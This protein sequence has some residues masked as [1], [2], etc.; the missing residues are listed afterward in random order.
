MLE[1]LTALERPAARAGFVALAEVRE[2]AR[3]G[4][5]GDRSADTLRT[6]WR[7]RLDGATRRGEPI[8]GL[9]EGYPPFPRHIGLI[10]RALTNAQFPEMQF[11]THSRFP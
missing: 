2:V 1:L 10:E 11:P 4:A 3:Y 6:W 5:A 8:G 7:T 9:F